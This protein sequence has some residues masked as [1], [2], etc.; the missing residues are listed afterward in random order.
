MRRDGRH[1]PHDVVVGQRISPACYIPG[2]F[3][4]SLDLAWKHA[5][6][7]EAGLIANTNVGGENCHRGVVV[8][9]LLGGAL[10]MGRIP[11]RFVDGIQSAP[12][13]RI[14]IDALTVSARD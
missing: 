3:P 4:A 6:D 10:G 8:G 13:L 9:A 14:Q 11:S 12:D 2:A 5:E 7:F 1:D